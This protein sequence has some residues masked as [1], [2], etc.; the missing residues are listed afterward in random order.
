MLLVT[1]GSPLWKI[2]TRG[3]FSH[4]PLQTS[5]A[6]QIQGSLEIS[7]KTGDE[8]VMLL[9]RI[10]MQNPEK[11]LREPLTGVQ[12]AFVNCRHLPQGKI[13]YTGFSLLRA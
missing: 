8:G 9:G 1:V 7:P 12:K 13:R 10:S 2:Q 6:N 5:A 4:W 11:L 3:V